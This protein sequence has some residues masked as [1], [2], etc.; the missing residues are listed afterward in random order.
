MAKQRAINQKIKC[1][2]CGREMKE[3]YKRRLFVCK[4]C[5]HKIKVEKHLPHSCK[6]KQ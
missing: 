5:R 2:K 4:H 3:G 6:E 1:I